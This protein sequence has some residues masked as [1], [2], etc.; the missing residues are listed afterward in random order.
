MHAHAYACR[1]T[2]RHTGR[3]MVRETGTDTEEDPGKERD[4]ERLASKG[5]QRE[6]TVHGQTEIHT[7]NV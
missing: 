2:W 1:E 5:R 3:L 7:K 4:T 6:R